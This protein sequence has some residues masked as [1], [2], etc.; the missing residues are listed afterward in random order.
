MHGSGESPAAGAKRCVLL[1]LDG[2]G[3]RPVA[4]LGGRT[5]LEAAHTPVLDRLASAGSYGLMDPIGQGVIPN[6][7]TGVGVL[8]LSMHDDGAVDV[9]HC[10]AGI[11]T[12]YVRAEDVVINDVATDDVC[13]NVIVVG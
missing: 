9:I 7:H 10:G 12:A 13:E 2:L 11:D 3:D 4:A 1:I 6:T 5:P 8:I